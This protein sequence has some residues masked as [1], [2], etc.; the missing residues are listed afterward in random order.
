MLIASIQ[1][2]LAAIAC[3]LLFAAFRWFERDRTIAVI[4]AIGLLVRAIVGQALFWISYL[5]LPFAR[6]LQ[7]GGGFWFYARD[8]KTYFERATL[9]AEQGLGAIVHIDPNM[10]SP[11]FSQVLALFGLLFGTVCST[12]LLMNLAA[13]LGTCAV[14]VKLAGGQKRVAAISV[15][16][17]SFSP[18]AI[19]WSTQ[20][21]KD[22][23]FLFLFAAFVGVA[24]GWIAVWRRQEGAFPRAAAITLAMLIVLCAI[25]GIR[26]Y[27]AFALLV[28][29]APILLVASLRTRMP[30]RAVGLLVAMYGAVL[31][32]A[33]WVAGEYLPDQLREL[34]T[35]PNVASAARSPYAVA[36]VLD[37]ARFAYDQ[38]NGSTKIVGTALPNSPRAA[39][40]VSGTAALL[41]PRPIAR[42]TGLLDM[43]GG[44]GLFFFADIDTLFF[45]LVLIAAVLALVRAP[46][47]QKWRSPLVWLVLIV[48]LAMG[49]SFVYA[50][51]NFGALFRYR[52]MIFI[53]I[54]M[55]PVVAAWSATPE[56]EGRASMRK[57]KS[58]WTTYGE[59]DSPL[60]QNV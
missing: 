43:S 20:P 57:K 52:S 9:A 46:R 22:V 45:D 27:F 28:I 5:A 49:A 23:L 42:A 48:T 11:G 18:S 51:S 60:A 10:V 3:G 36:S 55:I 26:W 40:F 13:Y 39:H 32:A 34:I 8:G 21:L 35:K 47:L 56:P 33:V 4:V 41:L 31:G 16:A 24:A 19:L 25:A 7:S 30:L 59:G 17:I 54:A 6:E 2:L 50:V 15:A 37:G 14:A 44:R 29:S 1:L 53:G 12:A 38:M 58:D